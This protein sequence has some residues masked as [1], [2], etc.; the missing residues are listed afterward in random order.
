MVV[1]I[2]VRPVMDPASY[3]VA[4]GISPSTPEL[5]KVGMIEWI[6]IHPSIFYTHSSVGSR[7]ARSLSQRSLGEKRGKPWTGCQ[8][9]TGPH[10]NMHVFG[11]WEEAGVPGE[12]PRIHVEN[13]QTLKSKLPNLFSG[14]HGKILK[15]WKVMEITTKLHYEASLQTVLIM[16]DRVVW[17]QLDWCLHNR[18]QM[19]NYLSQVRDI[20]WKIN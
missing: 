11:R 6:K 5:D 4:T 12:N 1:Y 18:I 2:C 13:M 20:F 9:I 14:F 17:C 15:S 3:P 8:S 16:S 7:G 10:T 19:L